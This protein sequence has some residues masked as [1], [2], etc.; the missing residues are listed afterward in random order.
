MFEKLVPRAER[1]ARARVRA[2]IVGL[3]RRLRGDLPT[4]VGVEP[5]PEGV[6]LSG[7]DLRRRMALD[8]CLR[9]TI[10]GLAHD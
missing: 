2:R 1:V 8:P 4:D 10:E 7:R 6:A 3:A 5:V 9:W